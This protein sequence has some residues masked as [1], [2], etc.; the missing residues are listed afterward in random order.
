MHPSWRRASLILLATLTLFRAVV[1]SRL[2]VSDDEAYYW[3]WAQHLAFGYV[4]HPPLVAWLISLGTFGGTLHSAIFLR[5]PSIVCEAIAAFMLGRASRELGGDER[6][7]FITTFIFALI[8]ETRLIVGQALPDPPYLL[9]WSA[10]LWF[11]LR[12]E[13][14]HARRDALILGVALG[15]ALLSRFFGW[16]LVGGIA[17]YALTPTKRRLWRDGLW[18]SFALALI[19]YAPNIAWNAAHAWLNF[20]F[21]IRDRQPIHHLSLARVTALSTVRYIIFAALF[22]AIAWWAIIRPR[23]TLLAWTALPFTTLLIM[24]GMMQR[25]ES[26][27]LLG[28][29]ASL[30]VGLGIAIPTL[31]SRIR[32]AMTTLWILAATATAAFV[33]LA[34]LPLP[35]QAQLFA[36][37]HGAL[38]GPVL[39]R[40]YAYRELTS[41]IT[42]IS[43]D[44]NPMIAALPYE[45]A[46][47]LRYRGIHAALIDTSPQAQQFALWPQHNITSACTLI[48]T[49]ASG[50]PGGTI[51]HAS[52]ATQRATTSQT[53]SY[54]VANQPALAFTM[55]TSGPRIPCGNTA[56]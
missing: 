55:L 49:F 40:S 47:Q 24:L 36:A 7:A 54:L 5:W 37:T 51:A 14:T 42:Q 43:A 52:I 13:R 21:T 45:I 20:A 12:F 16:A 9:A 48:I 39:D 35:R 8:P 4:D 6:A 2:P 46:A 30:C 23:L 33:T 34:A 25:V 29:F 1:G 17:I 53:I 26:Y 19:I 44:S 31:P 10:A 22:W 28:P 27:W 38:V 50:T 41:T 3:T 15:A 18:L 56:P 32:T 11:A